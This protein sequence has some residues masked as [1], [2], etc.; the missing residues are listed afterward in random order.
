MST[1]EPLTEKARATR[2]ALVRSASELFIEHG[3]GAVSVRDLARR[4]QVTSGAI[5]GHFRNKADLLVA[6]IADRIDSDLYLP[7]DG[8]RGLRG[9]MQRQW[10]SYRSRSG[11]RALLVEAAAAARVDPQV[12]QQ[13]H[14]LQ[15][16]RIAEWEAIYRHLQE[17]E[18]LD[19]TV[20]MDAVLTMLWAA[21]L[22]LGVL[23]SWDVEL[24]KPSAWGNVVD[25]FLGS[26]EPTSR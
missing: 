20:D 2:A 17:T 15:T 25:R 26:L 7:P 1:T 21:E 8:R 3:Y 9:Y 12:K 5:Y 14:D 4:T 13:L 24:P 16:A 19:P 10:K 6:A 18:G 23:E 11:L 22:G